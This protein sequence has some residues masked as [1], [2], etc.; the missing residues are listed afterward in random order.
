VD[1]RCNACALTSLVEREEGNPQWH[2]GRRVE[3]GA[4]TTHSARIL[5]A[6]ERIARRREKPSGERA[7]GTRHWDGDGEKIRFTTVA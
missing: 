4:P 1:G 5:R 6:A 2:G 7:R 3:G